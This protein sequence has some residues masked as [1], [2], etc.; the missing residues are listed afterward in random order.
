MLSSL[1]TMYECGAYH[2]ISF[3]YYVWVWSIL[4][5][6]LCLLCMSV[7]HIML[8]ALLV[9]F[10]C[11]ASFVISFAYYVWVWSIL[12]Y[13]LCLLYLSVKHLMLSAL[14]VI[15]EC[16]TSYVISFAYYAFSMLHTLIDSYYCIFNFSMFTHYLTATIVYLI[17]AYYTY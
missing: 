3:A 7:E 14:L 17:S 15:F 8:S 4:C 1:L 5:Y 9:I 12:C 13:Q 10:E 11:G 16:E 6:Q 2:V